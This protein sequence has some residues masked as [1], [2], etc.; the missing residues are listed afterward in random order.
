MDTQSEKY[1]IQT[2][3]GIQQGSVSYYNTKK[4]MMMSDGTRLYITDQ[5]G[6]AVLNEALQDI[7]KVKMQLGAVYIYCGKKLTTVNL[8]GAT[9][10]DILVNLVSPS[11]G[12]AN[13][14]TKLQDASQGIEAWKSY[15]KNHNVPVDGL[16]QSKG[17]WFLVICF[18]LVAILKVIDIAKVLFS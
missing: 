16:K 18:I 14:A 3:V 2:E 9:R 4:G 7:T 13:D 11:A 15:F 6:N 17:F 1:E 12:I 8:A 5:E 10:S